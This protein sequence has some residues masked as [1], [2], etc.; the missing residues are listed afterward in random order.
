MT[1]HYL[2]SPRSAAKRLEVAYIL[3]A[4]YDI[5]HFG[6]VCHALNERGADSYFVLRQDATWHRGAAK[7]TEKLEHYAR[8]RE[9]LDANQ[10]PYR[11][12]LN[13]QA[14]VALTTQSADC[15]RVCRNTK[16]KTSYGAPAI[17]EDTH[18]L[19]EKNE[20]FDGFL[21]HGQLQKDTHARY[22]DESRMKIV[23]IPRYDAFFRNPPKPAS[24]KQQLGL[25]NDKPIISYL[26]T[27]DIRNSTIHSF[28]EALTS[29]KGSYT[30]V[31]KPHPHTQKFNFKTGELDKLRGITPFVLDAC[32]PIEDAIAVADFLI[33]DVKSGTST[34]S[35][36]LTRA[37]TPW[38]GVTP[39]PKEAFFDVI[40]AAGPL[41]RDPRQLPQTIDQLLRNDT[42]AATRRELIDYAYANNGG[43]AAEAAT[44]A[45]IEFAHMEV[46]SR[47]FPYGWNKLKRSVRKRVQKF[48]RAIGIRRSAAA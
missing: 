44:N 14:D 23:G 40:T 20:G 47:Q 30:I 8:M 39:Y 41:V 33:T 1:E 22:F 37:R 34:E 3:A 13:P 28:H 26:P 45:I 6:P 25:P 15:L 35:M 43:R 7:K 2:E 5:A 16:L 38:I 4:A 18:Y 42:Y 24:V 9:L 48:E 32:G 27:W 12:K 10:L 11:H 29:L 36:Y 17:K 21:V 19:P 46:I 31:I